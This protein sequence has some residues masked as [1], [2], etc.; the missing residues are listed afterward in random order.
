[1]AWLESTQLNANLEEI[2]A[3]VEKAQ[4]LEPNNTRIRWYRGSLLKR[5]GKN[6]KAIGDFRFIVE[7]DPRHTDAQ[8]E[9]RLYDMRKAEQR[10]TGQ[11]TPSDRP[12]ASSVR[13]SGTPPAEGGGGRFGKWFKR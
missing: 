4:R 2:L 3:R 6:G 7:N 13:P 1:M 8:R 9:I 12:S 10:R 11:K 5:M